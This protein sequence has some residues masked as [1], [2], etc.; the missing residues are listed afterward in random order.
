MRRLLYEA[1]EHE[2]KDFERSNVAPT[3]LIGP[4]LLNTISMYFI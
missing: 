2:I 4:F 1:E 3:K